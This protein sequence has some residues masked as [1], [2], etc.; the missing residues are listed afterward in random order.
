LSLYLRQLE[1]FHRNG[2]ETISSNQLGQALAITD[3]QVRKDLAYFGQFGYPGIG[4]RV[5]ELRDSL[6]NVLGTNRTWQVALIGVGNLGRALLGYRGFQER[7]FN[8]T[9]LF[10][11]DPALIGKKIQG[12]EVLDLDQLPVIAKQRPV[13]LAVLAVPAAAAESV[14]QIVVA[15]GVP[16]ILNFAPVRLR[17]PE[18]VNV[19]SVDL[20]LQL[21]QLAFKV[22]QRQSIAEPGCDAAS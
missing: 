15:A 5:V 18:D 1:A 11:R 22:H 7:G 14:A 6:K 16:G 13:E 3:A 17:V 19:V 4:Y 9:A 2:H 8:V 12:M 10:D 21:E 20:G